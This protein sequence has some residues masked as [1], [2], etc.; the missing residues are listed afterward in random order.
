MLVQP[1]PHWLLDPFWIDTVDGGF[2]VVCEARLTGNAQTA[3]NRALQ[4]DPHHRAAADH[5]GLKEMLMDQI[6]GI[7]LMVYESNQV[8]SLI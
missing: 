8:V 5:E 4:R 7:Y 2:G 1:H 6:D 3:E